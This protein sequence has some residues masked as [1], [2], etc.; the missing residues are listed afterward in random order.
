MGKKSGGNKKGTTAVVE[1]PQAAADP[2]EAD[3][4]SGGPSWLDDLTQAEREQEEKK[5]KAREEKAAL[6]A[7]QTAKQNENRQYWEKEQEK[8]NRAKER[9]NKKWEA[10]LS[11][12]KARAQAEGIFESEDWGDGKWW[13]NLGGGTYKEV[14]GQYYCKLCDKHLNEN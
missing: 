13:V 12:A 1:V 8:A 2:H 10:E 9:E 7:K 6:A 3:E 4:T 14:Q 11:K 5:M